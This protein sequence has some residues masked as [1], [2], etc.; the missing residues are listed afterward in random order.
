MEGLALDVTERRQIFE[1]VSDAFVALDT[2]WCYTFVNAKAA[3]IFGRRHEDL[4]G[5]HIWTEFPA[6]IGQK[7]HKAY[8][9]AMAE[10]QP[11]FLEEYYPPYDRWFENRIYPSPEG[12]K[13]YFTDITERKRAEMLLREQ[14]QQLRLFVEHSPAAIAMFNCD[15]RYLV[16]SRR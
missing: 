3:K 6:G 7:F 10:Q 12:L 1:R 16:A 9:R 2:N 13:I 5:K 14:E 11:V 4:I 8:E 15:M